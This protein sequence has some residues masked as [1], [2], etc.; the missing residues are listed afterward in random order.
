MIWMLVGAT[1]ALF[2]Y[3]LWAAANARPGDTITEIVKAGA[4]KSWAVPFAFGFLMGHF[5]W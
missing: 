5:F 4:R 2:V 1:V 3:E